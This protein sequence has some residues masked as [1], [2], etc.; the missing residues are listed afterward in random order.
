MNCPIKKR[1]TQF[2]CC[3]GTARQMQQFTIYKILFRKD[4]AKH[5]DRTKKENITEDNETCGKGNE[6][7]DKTV[8]SYSDP[9]AV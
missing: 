6:P 7:N 8:S 2:A 1:L 9:V 4:R 5:I 3:D